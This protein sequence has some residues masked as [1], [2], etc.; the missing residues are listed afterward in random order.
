MSLLNR[1]SSARTCCRSSSLTDPHPSIDC[2]FRPELTLL[3]R[4]SPQQGTLGGAFGRCA[5]SGGEP[6]AGNQ[7]LA[8][9][10]TEA[11]FL[12]RS[13]TIGRKRFARAVTDAATSRGIHRTYSHTYVTRWLNGVTPRDTETRECITSALSRALGRTVHVA[14]VGYSERATIPTD[15]GLTYPDEAEAAIEQVSLLLDADLVEEGAMRMAPTHVGAWSDA[16]LSWLVG[17]RRRLPM[18]N[19][20]SR[21]TSADVRR[22]RATR[23][24]FDRLDNQFGG[25]HARRALLEYLRDDLH[26]LLRA[27]ASASVQRD[28]FSAAAEATQLAAWMAYD[29][30]TMGSRSGTSSRHSDLP[31]PP[32]TGF[33]PP[34]SWTR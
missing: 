24:L 31:M 30:A 22:L 10:M 5:Q 21:V 27:G 11:G 13:G 8:A 7:R 4:T 32:M 16:S 18:G 3:A 9:L 12:D 15:V 28:L 1:A 6:V 25:G 23:D 29:A 2:N 19:D 20:R 33:W 34:A 26:N 17:G 14:E